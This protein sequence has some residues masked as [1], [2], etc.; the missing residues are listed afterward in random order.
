FAAQSFTWAGCQSAEQN[1]TSMSEVKE[2]KEVSYSGKK[3]TATL[4]GGCFWCVEAIYQEL[5]G[6]ISVTSG[7]SGGI[8]KNPT[9]K[10]V[11][12]GI[13][14]HAEVIQVVFDPEIVSYEE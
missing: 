6:V 12:A 7:Y 4:G 9:Y 14:G 5:N 8:E 3:D 10:E 2:V 13:T 11:S 1:S